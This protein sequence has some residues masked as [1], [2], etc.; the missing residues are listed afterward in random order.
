MDLLQ[1]EVSWTAWVNI[2]M[3]D[4]EIDQVMNQYGSKELG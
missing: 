2:F 1:L 4:E 3:S